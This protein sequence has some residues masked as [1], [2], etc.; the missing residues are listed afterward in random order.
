MNSNST[1]C[2]RF[3]IAT[4]FGRNARNS[5][6]SGA[7]K[8]TPSCSRWS[9]NSHSRQNFDYLKSNF[10][11]FER[12]Q[13]GWIAERLKTLNCLNWTS[14]I[15][16]LENRQKSLA[17]FW[18]L[19]WSFYQKKWSHLEKTGNKRFSTDSLPSAMWM[20]RKKSLPKCAHGKWLFLDPRQSQ[21]YIWGII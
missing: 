21:L 10:R 3:H 1:T 19:V 16:P 8:Y 13:F 17:L 9:S 11:F 6:E 15:I 2:M 12:P 5:F 20:L 7:A 14:T 4:C 18:P